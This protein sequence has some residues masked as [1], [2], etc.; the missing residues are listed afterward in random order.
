MPVGLFLRVGHC[1]SCAG[2][3]RPLP[4]TRLLGEETQ[5]Q[6]CD[7]R[8]GSAKPQHCASQTPTHPPP[9]SRPF[10]TPEAPAAAWRVCRVSRVPAR[11]ECTHCVCDPGNAHF[12]KKGEPP[13]DWQGRFP[14]PDG[15]HPT[16][17]SLCSAR[18]SAWRGHSQRRCPTPR[19]PR[20]VPWKGLTRPFR[21][22]QPQELTQKGPLCKTQYKGFI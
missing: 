3:Q 13:Y 9:P 19:S 15:T 8:P 2:C 17:W 6:G 22:P 21:R 18:T 1:S 5:A 14:K 16:G 4:L 11:V 10:P 7:T 12:K 20:P